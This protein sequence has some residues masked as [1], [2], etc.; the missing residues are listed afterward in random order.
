[1]LLLRDPSGVSDTELVVSHAAVAVLRLFDGEH[2]IAD[3]QDTILKEHGTQLEY[4]QVEA[5]VRQFDEAGF[6]EGPTFEARRNDALAAYRTAPHWQP[7][8]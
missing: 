8:S 2:T 4:A 6:L 7:P 1:M 3:I 5:L